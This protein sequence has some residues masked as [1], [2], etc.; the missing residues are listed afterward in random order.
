MSIAKENKDHNPK[1][2]LVACEEDTYI[3]A[4]KGRISQVISNLLCNPIKFTKE[5]NI[6][7]AVEKKYNNQE[8]HVRTRDTGPGIHP[9]VLPRL[10]AKFASK[11]EIGTGLG[12]FISKSIIEAHGGKIRAENNPDNKGATFTLACLL[13]ANYSRQGNLYCTLSYYDLLG[14]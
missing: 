9:E 14:G 12:L 1:L 11:S 13:I 10:F 3:Q 6:T 2:Q 8:I 5:G 7:L 4:D